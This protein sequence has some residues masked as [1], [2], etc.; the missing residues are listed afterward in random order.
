M[1]FNVSQISYIQAENV[2]ITD[3]NRASYDGYP[4]DV[5][6]AYS[7]LVYMTTAR[8]ME[9]IYKSEAERD[10]MF[11]EILVTLNPLVITK[12]DLTRGVVSDEPSNLKA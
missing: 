4:R 3:R 8:S 1:V 2:T 9:L 10:V 12:P 11:K 7:I 6:K 5:D